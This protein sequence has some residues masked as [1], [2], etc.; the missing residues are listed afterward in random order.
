M[1]RRTGF[2]LVELLI[3]ISCISIL[4]MLLLPAMTRA[5]G[6]ARGV[7]CTSNLRQLGGGWLLYAE[8][9]NDYCMP[10]AVGSSPMTYWWGRDTNPPDHTQGLL[11]PYLAVNSGRDT[12]F[13]CPDQPWGSYPYPQG[14]CKTEPTSTYGYN[15]LYLATPASNWVF[16]PARQRVQWRT[17]DQIASP[18]LLFVFAD[19][20]IDLRTTYGN[21]CLLDGPLIPRISG[22]TTTWSVNAFPTLCFRHA[23]NTSIF[24]ADGHAGPIHMSQATLTSERCRTGTVGDTPAPHYVPNY[25]DW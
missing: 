8:T 4:S 16:G 25:Q 17:I 14:A 2:T 1:R 22:D 5:R 23:G 6:M 9:H 3:V 7:H 11:Y 10:Q 12:V 13:D 19:T 15:G 21:T 18:S 24:Y 20:L